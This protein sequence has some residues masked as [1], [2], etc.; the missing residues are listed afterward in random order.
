MNSLRNRLSLSLSVVLLLAGALLAFGLQDFPRRLVQDY[1]LARLAQ[2]ADLLYVHVLEDPD[3]P[4]AAQGAAG[5][6]YQLPLSGHYFVI[7]YGSELIRSRS[8]WDVDLPLADPGA[9]RETVL[10]RPGPAGQSLLVFGKRYP[11]PGGDTVVTVAEDI[12]PLEAAIAGF[13]ERLLIGVA[14]ALLAL[15]ALQR[16]LLVRGLAPL[17]EAVRACRRI[18][19]GEIVATGSD[20]AARSAPAEV[21]PMLDA[22]E[23]LARYH[24]QRLGRIRHAAGNLSHA[25]K[26]P[27]AVLAQ[28][29]DELATHGE[30]PLAARMRAQLDGMRETIERELQRARLAGGVTAGDPF[31]ARVQ[32]EALAEA[33]H[34]LYR[35]RERALRIE[36]EVPAQALPFDREDMLELFGNLLDNACKWA[37]A[38]VRVSMPVE[39]QAAGTVTLRIEDDGPGAPAALLGQL[40]TAG[41]R[42]DERQPGHGLGLSIVADIVSQYG[43]SVRYGRS[44]ALGGLQVEVSLPLPGAS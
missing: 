1:V 32:L 5:S 21:R 33:M 6:T 15:L 7:R 17:D 25:L 22:L 26:T 8:L 30:A 24:A 44:T 39:A 41:L 31:D 12:A 16:R 35:D 40:G 4:S 19:R 9:Q 28:G 23:R 29:V 36:L 38:R 13:R 34:R 43:G 37:R 14:L 2:D 11:T 42:G 3:P 20:V 27:L 18:E 10:R